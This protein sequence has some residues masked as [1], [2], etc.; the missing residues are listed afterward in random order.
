MFFS[1]STP[2][3]HLVVKLFDPQC[4]HK[5]ASLS[6]FVIWFA[7]CHSEWLRKESRGGNDVQG[8]KRLM[9]RVVKLHT[10]WAATLAA[11]SSDEKGRCS[12][13]QYHC[14]KCNSFSKCDKK[15]HLSMYNHHHYMHRM[16]NFVYFSV[17]TNIFVTRAQNHRSPTQRE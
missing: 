13:I 4:Q 8:K 3:T 15:Y 9:W 1:V 12:Q 11:T 10:I 2:P 7:C 6:L 17:L 14:N 5:L 16:G